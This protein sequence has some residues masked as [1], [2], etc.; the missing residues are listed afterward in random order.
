MVPT[1][2]TMARD[3]WLTHPKPVGG[4]AFRGS[5]FRWPRLG[6]TDALHSLSRRRNTSLVRDCSGQVSARSSSMPK[7]SLVKRH[8]E[9]NVTLSGVAEA[10]TGDSSTAAPDLSQ[11]TAGN[12][13]LQ[14]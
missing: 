1:A 14:P 6:P 13:D 4:S 2:R 7:T 10:V 12:Y 8:H 11:E 9:P 5:V 3:A